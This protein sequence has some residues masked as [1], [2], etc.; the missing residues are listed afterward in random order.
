M[1]QL[2]GGLFNQSTQSEMIDSHISSLKGTRYL[3]N[4][5]NGDAIWPTTRQGDRNE[6]EIRLLKQQVSKLE[7]TVEM[8]VR[9]LTEK[10]KN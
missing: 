3:G 8:L 5:V 7:G 4:G 10:L 2:L 1:Y 9:L 6:E